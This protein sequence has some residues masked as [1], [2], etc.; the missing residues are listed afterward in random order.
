MTLVSAVLRLAWIS[1]PR[2]LLFDE[3]YYVN[4]ARKILGLRMP[5]DAFYVTAPSGLD[6]NFSHPPLGKLLISLGIRSLGDRPLGWRF[7]A[8]LFGSYAILALYWLARTA[9]FTPWI[10]LGASSLMA[11]DPMFFIHGRIGTLEILVLTFML[12]A[13]AVYLGE[14]P[15]LAG[16]VVGVGACIKLVALFLLGAFAA[17]ELFR[18]LSRAGSERRLPKRRR[19]QR[20][21][22]RAVPKRLAALA[23][24]STTALVCYFGLLQLLDMR[25]T[26]FHNSIH[27]T[28]A[29]LTSFDTGRL[30]QTIID[31]I[32]P[33]AST[34]ISDRP[35]TL[36]A[37]SAPK[38]E[39][40]GAD[41]PNQGPVTAPVGPVIR[42]EGQNLGLAPTSSP[43]QWLFNE[44]PINYYRAP[45][46][47]GEVRSWSLLGQRTEYATLF[48]VL[49]NPAIIILALP[50]LAFSFYQ[51]WRKEDGGAFLP[52][53]WFLGT[54][55]FFA[56][57]DAFRPETSG[58]LY[59]MVVVLPAIYLAVAQL[60][61]LEK[62][63]RFLP[64]YG[65]IVGLFFVLNFPFKT[66]GGV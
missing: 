37:G 32:A 2:L 9:G 64:L 54:F 26:N 49:I 56:L 65:A 38:P 35:D 51:A 39:P 28:W 20:W 58:H 48:R 42:Q 34:P 45:T 50:A 62:P 55:G 8:I 1:N 10:S 3:N 7:A 60:F 47:R 44:E 31:V 12:V 11:A 16:L 46:F 4:A 6:P 43:L 59:Y 41:A 19:E 33:L 40:R 61:T 36:F 23:L 17:L 15:A 63:K 25:F 53:A 22:R 14:R 27:H 66:W 21:L 57:S 24:T 5:S 18:L 29:M 30:D 13:T 52:S